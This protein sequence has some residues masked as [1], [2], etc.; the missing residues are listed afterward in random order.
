MADDIFELGCIRPE[1]VVLEEEI[2][3]SVMIVK[4]DARG[5]RKVL[6]LMQANVNAIVPV[7]LPRIKHVLPVAHDDMGTDTTDGFDGGIVWV[8]WVDLG[9]DVEIP[10]VNR[11][12]ICDLG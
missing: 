3:D 8:A 4:V 1:I 7:S 11:L 5:G 2:L 9:R 6:W 12:C 10:R